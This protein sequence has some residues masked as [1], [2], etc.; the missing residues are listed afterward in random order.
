MEMVQYQEAPLHGKKYMEIYLQRVTP[1]P[2]RFDRRMI[3]DFRGLHFYE[4]DRIMENYGPTRGRFLPTHV[5]PF[6]HFQN[7]VGGHNVV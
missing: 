2:K 4:K 7:S 5:E 3:R 1:H 6:F